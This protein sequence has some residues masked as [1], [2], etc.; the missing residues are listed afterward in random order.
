M[1]DSENYFQNKSENEKNKILLNL[2]KQIVSG[3]KQIHKVGIIHSDIKHLNIMI[4][5]KDPNQFVAYIID[6]GSA[7]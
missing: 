1:K 2:F 6:L 3:V 4:E 5:E 7:I